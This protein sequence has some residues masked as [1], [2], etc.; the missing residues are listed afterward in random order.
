[1]KAEDFARFW[2]HQGHRVIQTSSCLWYNAHPWSYLS[3][4]YHRLLTPTQGEIRRV[5][6]GGPALVLRYPAP[7]QG[8]TTRGGLF[9][10]SNRTYDLSS[11]GK[12]AR[13]QTRRGLERCTVR[14]IELSWLAEHGHL[15]NVETLARQ[16][17]AADSL[18]LTQWKAYCRAAGEIA[19]F[20]AWGAFVGEQLAAFMVAAL[21]EEW[22]SILCQASRT[23]TLELSPNNALVYVVTQAK[24][25]SCDVGHV[26]Y[27][28]KSL[29]AT[30]GL[31]H[32][33]EQMGFHLQPFR[34]CVVLHPV[35]RIVSRVGAQ[36]MVERLAAR[37]PES[38]LWRKASVV[39]RMTREAV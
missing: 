10:C 26:S 37:H 28:M 30:G 4:P 33:K 13:N 21:V 15:L 25:R 7:I 2:Q 20:E 35:L 11:L 6:W 19:G 36:A 38:D 16:G 9:V 1:M 12:K 29:E 22:F 23:S 14:P 8:D 39:L 17:R 34:E 31:D 5:L 27:G 18:T 24:L 32:F 3:T